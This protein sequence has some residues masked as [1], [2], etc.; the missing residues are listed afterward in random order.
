MRAKLG[1]QAYSKALEFCSLIGSLTQSGNDLLG[2]FLFA[3]SPG[4][5]ISPSARP[6]RFS[7]ILSALINAQSDESSL[8]DLNAACQ[9]IGETLKKPSIVFILSD[10]ESPDFSDGLRKLV[11]RHD[12]VLVQMQP[13]ISALPSFGLVTFQDAESG[14][15]CVVDTSSRAVQKAWVTA[16][17]SRLDSVRNTAKQCGADHIVITNNTAQPLVEL[18]KERVHRLSR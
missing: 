10:F 12:V 11:M 9:H 8:T 6:R 13:D 5:F 18:M 17:Q 16:L 2:L 7:R 4:E 1:N 3:K 15:I 14:D